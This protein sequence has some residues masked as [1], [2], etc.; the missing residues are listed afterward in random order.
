VVA[1]TAERDGSAYG[2]PSVAMPKR[3]EARFWGSSGELYPD[4]VDGLEDGGGAP[5][6]LAREE[7]R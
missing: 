7:H 5:S 6:G 2:V 3:V 4:V 1:I